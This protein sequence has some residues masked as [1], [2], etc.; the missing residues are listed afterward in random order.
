VDDETP[1]TA[2]LL[3]AWRDATRASELAERLAKIASDAAD[4]AEDNAAAAHEV[5]ALAGEAAATAERA[6]ETARQ[7][8]HRAT[9]VALRQRTDSDRGIAAV[10]DA[11]HV[12]G[13]AA[14][15]YH[16]AEREAY[17]RNH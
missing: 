12:E 6:A 5:A 15:R 3:E 11:Q 2:E 7:A 8:A 4:R 14:E 9:E 10:T 16:G 1:S 13:E 17:N